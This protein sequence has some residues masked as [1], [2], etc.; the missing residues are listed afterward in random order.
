MTGV[1]TCALPI[2]DVV[3]GRNGLALRYGAYTILVENRQPRR[4]ETK[5]ERL[6][7]RAGQERAFKAVLEWLDQHHGTFSSITSGPPAPGAHVPVHFKYADTAHGL[8]LACRDA[9][10]GQ[11]A[12]VTLPR[13]SASVVVR[14]EVPLPGGYAVPSGLVELKTV[15]RRHGFLSTH[16]RA[17]ERDRKSVV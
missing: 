12:C 1:Q 8:R 6:R 14:R 5:S 3:D 11:P 10:H 4:T 17:G 7:L 9:Q 16:C 2:S 13:Y 15:L